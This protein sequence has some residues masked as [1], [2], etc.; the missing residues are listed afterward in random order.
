MPQAG[1]ALLAA[2]D[3]RSAYDDFA[4]KIWPMMSA[5]CRCLF[6]IAY[7]GFKVVP[8]AGSARCRRKYSAAFAPLLSVGVYFRFEAASDAKDSRGDMIGELLITTMRQP[9]L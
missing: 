7:T 6:R 1:R 5:R 8:H 4:Q 3:G 2:S 9:C